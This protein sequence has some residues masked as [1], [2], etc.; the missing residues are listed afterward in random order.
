L[1]H[2]NLN[3]WANSFGATRPYIPENCQQS[4]HM[5]YLL[6]PDLQTRQSFI[7]FLKERGVQAVFHYVPL[8]TS[9][10]GLRIGYQI[11]QLPITETISDRLV[12]LPFHNNLS[13]SEQQYVIDTIKQFQA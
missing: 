3:D 2:A 13:T 12:R 8:H 1:Y 10:M 9:D 7:Q 5:Y 11:G 4:Y 6:M